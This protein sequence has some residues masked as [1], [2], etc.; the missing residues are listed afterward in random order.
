M[1]RVKLKA[2]LELIN[3]GVSHLQAIGVSGGCY[4]KTL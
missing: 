1:E 4:T 3:D 2:N